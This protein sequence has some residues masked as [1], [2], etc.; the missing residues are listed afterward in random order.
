MSD[1]GKGRVTPQGAVSAAK[2][3]AVVVTERKDVEVT[4]VLE[5]VSFDESS[6]L[7]KTVVGNLALEGAELRVRILDVEG[8]RLSVSGELSML[9]YSTAEGHRGR[10][11]RMR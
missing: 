11:G 7:L 4:G 3:H 9:Y 8:G 10:R 5:V 6:V 1:T 2:A